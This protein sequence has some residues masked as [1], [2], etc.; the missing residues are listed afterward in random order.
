MGIGIGV[1]LPLPYAGADGDRP[2]VIGASD[3][4]MMTP[5]AIV[6]ETDKRWV[7]PST[8]IPG[9]RKVLIRTLPNV[10]KQ[11]SV[12]GTTLVPYIGA[13]F[14]GGYATD[15]DRLLSPALSNPVSSS[16]STDVGLGSLAGQMIP[17]EVQVGIRFP[18]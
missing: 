1:G 10:S 16:N 6:T 18:F 7:L 2:S 8:S 3:S 17:N 11:I 5:T 9:D 13:G 12:A 14:R 4:D 15:F